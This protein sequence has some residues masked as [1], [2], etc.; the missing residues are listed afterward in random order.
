MNTLTNWLLAIPLAFLLGALGIALDGEDKRD[1]MRVF[2]ELD[3]AQK[4]SA[5][6]MRREIAG[7]AVCRERHGEADA[8][9][10]DEGNL[11]C[12]PRKFKEV[13]AL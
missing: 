4:Q 6:L 13:A 3:T 7:R 11:I 10:D 8:R 5:A 9:W 1:E 2:A 12:R